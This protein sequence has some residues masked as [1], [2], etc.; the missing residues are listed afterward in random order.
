MMPGKIRQIFN[1]YISAAFTRNVIIISGGTAFGQAVNL[2]FSPIITRLYTP[3]EY[4][5]LTVYSSILGILSIAAVLRYEL[6]I[7][8]A[9]DDEKTV[10]VI[11]LCIIV[12]TLF[13][14][15]IALLLFV[16]GEQLLKLF[17]M[18]SLLQY[19][20]MIPVGIFLAGIYSI[21]FQWALRKKQFK[22]ITKTKISQGIAQNVVT[23][24]AGMAHVG[25]IGLIAGRVVGQSA[26]ITTL[27]RSFLK[28]SSH[29]IKK[30]NMKEIL[31]C[32]KRFK[33]FPLYGAPGQILNIAGIQLPVLLITA[34][35]GPEAVGFYGLA[36]G[37]VNLPMELIGRSVSDVFYA[38]AASI[39]KTDPRRLR[40]LSGKLIINLIVIGLAPLLVLL[41]LGPFLFSAVFGNTWY[42]A[43]VYAQ[44]IAVIVFAR[45][46]FTPI[47]RLFSVFERQ[48]EALVLDVVRVILVLLVFGGAR[49]FSLSAY[50]TVALYAG[51][52]SAVYFVSFL[53]A[54]QIISAKIKQM[55]A[56]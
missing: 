30:V 27:V 13:N 2:L 8:I 17:D 18:R 22:G 4:G 47:S 33:D 40:T 12:V 35:Y 50:C 20:Y 10:N 32:A 7:P 25:A 46:I 5:V 44:I 42:E 43:G 36:N 54:Q 45:F 15:F 23:V 37:V 38:E 55:T 21:F 9:D 6:G 39:G 51:V 26:G 52:M 34:L 11:A 48:R 3:E 41:L 28:E 29:L 1:R 31:W 53:V 49:W 16:W 24:G 19:Q 14:L 56:G